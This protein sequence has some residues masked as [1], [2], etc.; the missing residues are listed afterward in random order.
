MNMRNRN[1]RNAS[2]ASSDFFSYL[3]FKDKEFEKKGIISGM[4]STGFSVLIPE[5]GLEGFI[6]FESTSYGKQSNTIEQENKMRSVQIGRAQVRMFN[7]VWVKIQVKLKN[8]R[9]V[10][11]LTLLDDRD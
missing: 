1:A 7:W 11:E 8:F 6:E 3:F 2:R 9:K 4:Q 10:I 5:F